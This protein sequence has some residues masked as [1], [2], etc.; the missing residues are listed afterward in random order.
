MKLAP[1]LFALAI[2]LVRAVV[3]SE[4]LFETTLVFPATPNNKPNYRI[5]AIIQAPNGDVLIIAEKR[6]DGIGDIGNHDIV[7][8]RS[9][10]QGRTWSREQV[11]F[12]DGDRTCTDLTVG[13]DRSNGKLWLFFLRDKKQFDYFTSTSG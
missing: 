7:L 9:G 11:I 8:K 2:L 3:A 12:D 5:P 4:P 13:L 1:A 6:N 10:D